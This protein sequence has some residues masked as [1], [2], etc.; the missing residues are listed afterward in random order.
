MVGCSV[1]GVDSGLP[2]GS[3]VPREEAEKRGSDRGPVAE[4]RPDVWVP[5]QAVA[6]VAFTGSLGCS[7]VLGISS[8]PVIVSLCLTSTLADL[9]PAV[10]SAEDLR[11][12]LGEFVEDRRDTLGDED[13]LR[14]AAVMLESR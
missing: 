11:D 9:S 7:A 1:S 4:G 6:A 2:G 8:G 3:T 13:F 5:A 10:L 12:T 14:Q